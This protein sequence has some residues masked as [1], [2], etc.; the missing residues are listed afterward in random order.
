[1]S[2]LQIALLGFAA[3]WAVGAY[4]LAT[5]RALRRR[6]YWEAFGC[7]N[8][9]VATA[10]AAVILAGRFPGL[11]RLIVGGP[12]TST[13]LLLP[14]FGIPPL[15]LLRRTETRTETVTRVESSTE[16]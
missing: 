5:A 16:G 2:D 7:I 12:T 6:D 11:P 4:L 15:L 3:V 1:M 13:L 8:L 14:I 10:F 9:F